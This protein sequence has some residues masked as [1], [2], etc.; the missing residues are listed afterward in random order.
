MAASLLRTA[1]TAPQAAPLGKNENRTERI[2]TVLREA[3]RPMSATEILIEAGLPCG[4]NSGLV[5]ALL[6]WDLKQQ[7]VIFQDYR[8]H[9][10]DHEAAREFAEIRS[11]TQL[12][13]RH[14]LTVSVS[15]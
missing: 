15:A 10:N 4:A 13:R 5:G 9:W 11:A 3:G 1:S 8:Y 7:R 2:R 12:L 6:K 14:G